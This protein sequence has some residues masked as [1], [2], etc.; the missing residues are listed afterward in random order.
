MRFFLFSKVYASG[1]VFFKP[2]TRSPSFHWPR[3]LSS[4]T[5]SKRLRTVRFEPEFE[6]PT[7]KLLCCD[8]AV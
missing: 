4:E 7:L 1:L 8:M 5:R 3:F 6:A 2:T